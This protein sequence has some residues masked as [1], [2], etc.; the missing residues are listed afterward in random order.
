MALSFPSESAPLADHGREPQHAKAVTS[1]PSADGIAN[2]VV[3]RAQTADGPRPRMVETDISDTKVARRSGI[4]IWSEWT[5]MF[6]LVPTPGTILLLACVLL[7]ELIAPR[8]RGGSYIV[9]FGHLRSCCIV[10][11]G[12][13][14]DRGVCVE[15]S[16][17]AGL[18]LQLAS[19]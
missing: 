13:R 3:G 16:Q 15:S 17:S 14:I 8:S 2:A 1:S 18:L 19:P 10:V 7:V 12:S 4:H 5:A 6:R 11:L 9:Q